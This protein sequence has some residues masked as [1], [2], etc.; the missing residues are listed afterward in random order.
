MKGSVIIAKETE[1]EFELELAANAATPF[2]YHELFKEDFLTEIKDMDEGRTVSAFTKCAF[3]MA[4]QAE[5]L[6]LKDFSNLKIEQ[7]YEWLD[8]FEPMDILNSIGD[9]TTFYL[10]QTEGTASPKQGA[11]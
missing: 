5:G 4:K 2:F 7:F 8:G 6:S 9:I 3:I 1:R 10:G 11:E